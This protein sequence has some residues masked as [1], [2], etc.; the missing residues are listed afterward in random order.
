[1]RPALRRLACAAG[2]ALL[3]AQA[4]APVAQGAAQGEAPPPSPQLVR[5]KEAFAAQLLADQASIGRIAAS[6]SAEAAQLLQRARG[7][8]RQALA[9]IEAGKGARANSLLNDVIGAMAR[10]RSLAPDPAVRAREERARHAQLKASLESLRAS[11][12]DHLRQLGREVEGD[13]TWTAVSRLLEEAQSLAAGERLGEANR[14][15]L[16]AENLQLDAFGP[17]LAGRTLDYTAR[18]SSLAEEFRFELERHMDYDALVPLA[19]AELNP[20]EG[21]RQLV[22]RYVDSGLRLRRTAERHAATGDYSGALAS[23]RAG[24]VFL[25]RALLAAGLVVPLQGGL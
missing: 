17:L 6:G 25:Q 23:I 18:F 4:A 11:Y 10:A 5:Q 21:A 8:Y 1:M 20:G 16:Q 24:T 2:V 13:G 19:I 12:H 15:L 9:A 3:A 7:D 14:L 22:S